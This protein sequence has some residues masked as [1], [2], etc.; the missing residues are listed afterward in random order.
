MTE[1][2]QIR[3]FAREIIEQTGRELCAK[4][5]RR[6]QIAFR[7]KQGHQDIVTEYDLW[8]EKRI[9]DAIRRRFPDHAILSEEGCCH[10]SKGKWLWILDPIDGTTNFLHMGNHYAISLGVYYEGK[11]VFGWVYDA[12]AGEFCFG[13]WERGAF[14]NGFPEGR[15]PG[16]RLPKEGI[17]A[18]SYKTMRYLEGHG[19]DPLALMGQFQ[20]HRYLGCASMELCQ[21]ADGA[22]DLYLGARL[23]IWDIA[24]AFLYL[25]ERGGQLLVAANGEDSYFTAAFLSEEL[26]RSVQGF[27]PEPIQRNLVCFGGLSI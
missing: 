27:L 24:A 15:Q 22:C 2:E 10:G 11:P 17:L 14:R 7:E 26:F 9:T 3:S 8:T 6:P 13:E 20:G 19:S 23:K 4:R 12:A 5:G 16:V 18:M 1:R 25:R 21:V